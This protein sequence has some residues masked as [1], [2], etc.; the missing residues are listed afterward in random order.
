MTAI[1]EKMLSFLRS[2]CTPTLG[3]L[4]ARLVIKRLR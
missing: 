2:G 4:F 3:D 1:Q